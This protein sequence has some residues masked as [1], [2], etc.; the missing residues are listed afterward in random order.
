MIRTGKNKNK[1]EKK[2]SELFQYYF[3]ILDL[4]GRR[5]YS[6]RLEANGDKGVSSSGTGRRVS[7]NLRNVL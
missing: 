1:I 4:I 3:V 5:Q 6:S 7:I 2:L